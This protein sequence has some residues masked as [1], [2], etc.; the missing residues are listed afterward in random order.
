MQAALVS[1]EKK[2]PVLQEEEKHFGI[3][4]YLVF[5]VPRYCQMLFSFT[6]VKLLASVEW[7]NIAAI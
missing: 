2:D 4:I 3:K 7:K 5:I 6:I 1:G